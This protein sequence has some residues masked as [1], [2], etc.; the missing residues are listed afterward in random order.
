MKLFL[1]I[2][3]QIKIGLLGLVLMFVI[4]FTGLAQ[5]GLASDT[6]VKK[7]TTKTD[8]IHTTNSNV[9]NQIKRTETSFFVSALLQKISYSGMRVTPED[10]TEIRRINKH[11]DVIFYLM[12]LLILFIGILRSGFPNYFSNMVRV[13]FNTSLRQNQLTDQLL[14]SKLPSLLF[15]VFF[16]MMSGLYLFIFLGRLKLIE[17]SSMSTLLY[18]VLFIMSMY[19]VKYFFMQLFG[20]FSGNEQA[21]DVY[22]FMVFLVNKF[23]AI[24]LLPLTMMIYYSEGAVKDFAMVCSVLLVIVFFLFRYIRSFVLLGQNLKVSRFHFIL[25]ILGMEILPILLICKWGMN[26]IGKTL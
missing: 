5:N 23:M 9:V 11:Q 24:I 25:F 26:I 7:D 17:I 15:N 21:A 14:Q 4:S 16:V 20:W 6:L 10:R 12:L 19:L 18:M 8:T 1:F 22:V 3:K 13:F 2:N